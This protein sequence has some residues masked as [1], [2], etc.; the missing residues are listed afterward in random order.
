MWEK[1]THNLRINGHDY[2]DFI[3][4]GLL[5]EHRRDNLPSPACA[6]RTADSSATEPFDEV[7]DRNIWSMYAE[8]TAWEVEVSGQRKER[9][10]QLRE[11][12]I[13]MEKRR[14]H[15]EWLPDGDEEE[16]SE[17]DVSSALLGESNH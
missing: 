6:R 2:E 15:A 14:N 5:G 10:R 17:L 1:T 16:E 9:P 13:D 12:E 4:G 11:G 8:R 7:L 3:Q